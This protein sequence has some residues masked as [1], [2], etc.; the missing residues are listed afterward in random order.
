MKKWILVCLSCV[1]LA[2]TLSFA[3]FLFIGKIT[4]DYS[5][6]YS[7][8]VTCQSMMRNPKDY[9]DIQYRTAFPFSINGEA[10]INVVC[11]NYSRIVPTGSKIFTAWQFYAN[12]FAYSALL[13]GLVFASK[14]L[15]SS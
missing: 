1:F 2:L 8:N 9:R 4:P 15:K 12:T 13:A 7:P 5:G 10:R 14:K 6:E 3:S 11:G